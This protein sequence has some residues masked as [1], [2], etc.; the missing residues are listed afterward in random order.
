MDRM[1]TEPAMTNELQRVS[2]DGVVLRAAAQ[3]SSSD[4]PADAELPLGAHLVTQRTGYSHHGIYVGAGRVIHYAGLCGSLHRGPVEE[5]SIER[6]AA[7][8]DVWVRANPLARYVGPEAVRRARSRLGENRYRLLTNNCEHFCTWCLY[9]ESHS[10]QVRAC[11]AHP[12]MAV[13]AV[14]SLARAFIG[15]RLHT[16]HGAA[17]AA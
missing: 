3:A 12:R 8:H 16:M 5:I 4:R 13:L 2:A 17:N 10:E 9:G 6:F 11:V 14:T 7:G 1:P 15:M